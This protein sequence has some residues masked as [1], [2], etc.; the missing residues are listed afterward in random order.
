MLVEDKLALV[1]AGLNQDN[2][3][4]RDWVQQDKERIYGA[5]TWRPNEKITFRAN[6]ENGFEH[7]TTLQPS[8]VTDQVLPWYDNMLALGV[9]AVTFR[10]TGGNPNA[11]RRLVG[12]VA[13]DGNYNN[14]QNRFTYIENDGTFYNAAGTFIT[15]GYDDERVQHPDGT[16]GLGDRPHR[17]NDQSFLPYERNPGGPDFYRDSDFSSYSAFLDIQITNDWF[18]NVQFGNQEVR[19]DTPQ[20][21]GPRPEFRADPNT[22]Q[23][24]GGPDNPYVGRFYFDGNYRRDKNI[25]TYEEIRVS[26]SYNLD[27]GSNIFGR[28]RLAIAASEVD[29]KQRRGNTWL[30]LAGNPFG[31]GNFVDTYGNVYPRSN[32]LNANN[33]VTIRNYFDFNDPKTWKAG[34]WKSLPETLTT[35]RFSENGTPIEYKV[36]WAEAEPGNINYQIAQVTESQMAVSQ[37]HFWDDRFVVTLGY[38]RDKVVIDRAGHYRDPDV[39]WIP[40]LSITPDTPP[41]DNTIPGSPQTEFDSD[42]R[43]AGAV[44]HINDNFSLIANKATNIGIPDFRRTVYPDGA[45]SPPPNGDGQDFGI[46]FSALDNRISGRLVYYETNSIQE[47]VGGSQAS[48]PIDTIYDAYQDAYQ[49][50]GMENQSALDAL[51]ARARELNPDVNGYFRDNVS[52]GYEL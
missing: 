40:D 19:I 12:V 7:R 25:S 50:P 8:T 26:T 15:G 23:G 37:S 35:D 52:S 39:G 30:A 33:R 17:I 36:I 6:Y 20:L 18:F 47:V 22:N 9:D 45:T 46:G 42:V 5:L 31:A 11:A 41:D 48:N 24:I 21:Q 4:W 3:H 43:T 51:N 44:F 38:R 16:A 28:H 1:V 13:R 32:Y 27:T 2:G 29:E 14:G 10:S 49:I 34:S